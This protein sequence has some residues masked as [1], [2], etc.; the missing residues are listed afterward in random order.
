MQFFHFIYRIKLVFYTIYRYIKHTFYS[1]MTTTR[2]KIRCTYYTCLGT[3]LI[4]EDFK[5]PFFLLTNWVIL[6]CNLFSWFVFDF[7]IFIRVSGH[8]SKRFLNSLLDLAHCPL[9]SY[10]FYIF[11]LLLSPPL[12][13]WGY[14]STSWTIYYFIGNFIL[15][16][17]NMNLKNKLTFFMCTFSI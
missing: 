6:K 3:A 5:F 8:L 2:T 9:H 15:P 1:I 10:S 4:T 14:V 11:K 13:R 16:I 17:L 7:E 12:I